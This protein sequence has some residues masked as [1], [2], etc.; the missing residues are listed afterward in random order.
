MTKILK[1]TDFFFFYEL[2][3]LKL[4][5]E[6]SSLF[7]RDFARALKYPLKNQANRNLK[8][9]HLWNATTKFWIHDLNEHKSHSLGFPKASKITFANNSLLHVILEHKI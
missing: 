6:I 8:R 9:Y 2:H 3:T 5:I 7:R 4:W 1:I